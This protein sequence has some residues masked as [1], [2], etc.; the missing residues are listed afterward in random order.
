MFVRRA[1][2][3]GSA[4]QPGRSAGRMNN[5]C[6]E[7]KKKKNESQQVVSVFESCMRTLLQGDQCKQSSTETLLVG[8][9]GLIRLV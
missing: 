9:L 4:E 6:R 2:R 3:G 1:A 8:H 5:T 7:E